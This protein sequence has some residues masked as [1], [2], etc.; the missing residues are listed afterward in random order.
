MTVWERA[1]AALAAWA[2][3]GGLLDSLRGESLSALLPECT[4]GAAGAAGGGFT[5]GG[6]YDIIQR[7]HSRKDPVGPAWTTTVATKTALPSV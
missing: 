1:V 7:S 2:L 3:D 6:G 5:S 4:G